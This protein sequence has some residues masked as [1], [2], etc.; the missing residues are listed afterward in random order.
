MN[1]INYTELK[2]K[3]IGIG[4]SIITA[5]AGA[6]YHVDF[7]A[8]A[9]LNRSL[10]LSKAFCELLK[11]KNFIAAAPLL[12]LQLDNALRFFA[13][14]LVR[15]PHDFVMDVFQGK[16]ICKMKDKDDQLMRDAYLVAKLNNVHPWVEK[17][18]ENTSGYI[19]L[20]EKHIFHAIE[21]KSYDD[22][23]INFNMKISD[24]D[25][26]VSEKYYYEAIHA[27]LK[28]TE[29]VYELLEGW[30]FTKGNPVQAQKLREDIKS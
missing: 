24:S 27:Y 1:E 14:T 10:C 19:H 26:F 7:L 21:N 15:K 30:A 20:S 28:T 2:K 25:S 17:V 6:L 8:I 3:H 18:Y 5:N 12:R 9:S 22:K 29:I 16:P 11:Q 23:T 13:L 4:K